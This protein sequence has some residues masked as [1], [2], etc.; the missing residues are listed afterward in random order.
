MM[1][2]E[3]ATSA[4][5]EHEWERRIAEIWATVAD[6]SDDD[7]VEA[8]VALVKLR[9]PD[10]AAGLYEHASALDYAGREAEAEPLYRR[11]LAAGLDSDRRSQAAIQL[12][13]TLRNLGRP[14][15]SV[16]LLRAELAAKHDDGFDDA[17]AGFLALALAD[18]GQALDAVSA[19]LKALAG[20]LPQYGRA[21]GYYADELIDRHRDSNA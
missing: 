7:V 3:P 16:A 19:A 2:D 11:A 14:G 6:R 9:P 4:S 10:D 5:D 13:S 1:S 20:H 18:S 8:V 15:E 17:R 21:I 12:A